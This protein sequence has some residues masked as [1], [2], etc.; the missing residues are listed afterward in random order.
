MWIPTS[1]VLLALTSRPA[2]ADNCGSLSDCW[3]Q[4]AIAVLVVVALAILIF[5]FWEFIVAGAAAGGEGILSAA[6][7]GEIIGWGT[8]QSAEAVAV[9][10]AVTESLTTEAVE[11]MIEEGLTKEFVESQVAAYERA[12]A[13]GGAKLLNEQLLPRLEL[14][15]KILN[16]WPK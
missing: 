14:M 12:V 3:Y 7:Y 9:T 5:L 11:G 2:F 6:E 15:Q 4:I 10:E 8:G 13:Q 1:L 16:L